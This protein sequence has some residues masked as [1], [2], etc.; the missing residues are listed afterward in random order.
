MEVLKD[1]VREGGNLIA[2]YTT[3]LCDVNGKEHADFG[4]AELFGVR[5]SGKKEN[6]RR[7]NYQYILDKTH[8]V[9]KA[10][11]QQTELLFNAGYTALT[12]P[13]NTAKVIC[14]WVPTIQNQPPDKAWVKEF[15]TEFPTVVE[16]K[17]GRGT[18]LYFANQPDLL[19]YETGHPDPRNLLLRTIRYLAGDA[20]PLQTNAPSSVHIGLTG[21]LQKPGQY[22]L[23]LVNTTSGSFRPIRD[24]VP[25]HDI[26]LT[27]RLDGRSV[28]KCKVLR[29]QGA[30]RIHSVGNKLEIQI[31]KLEDFCAIHVQMIL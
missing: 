10:D 4:L 9:V 19:S 26:R 5:Y 6:T 16:N 22:N 11:S 30:C 20:L 1:Y 13:L 21:S 3:S 15:S 29:S 8:P 17:Y 2:T 7:D 24:L 18:V 12:K 25:V 28:G 23:S 27:L 14:T 31:P